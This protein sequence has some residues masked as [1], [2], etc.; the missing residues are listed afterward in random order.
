MVLEAKGYIKDLYQITNHLTS[1][2]SENP[3]PECASDQD[4][5]EK[6]GDFFLEKILKIRALFEDKD[7]LNI[8]HR[9]DI[10]MLTKFAPMSQS[11]VLKVINSMKTES[12]ELDPLPTHVVKQIIKTLST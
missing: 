6:F 10:P 11:D 7:I 9:E 5:A 2:H 1:Y 8:K 3:I 4:S 12:C